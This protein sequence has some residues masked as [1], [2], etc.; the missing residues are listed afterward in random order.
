[1]LSFSVFDVVYLGLRSDSLD[2]VN[3]LFR[4]VPYLTL[5][6]IIIYFFRVSLFN[7][8]SI[9]AQMTQLSLRMSLCQFIQSYADYSKGIISDNKDLLVRFE[10]IIFSNIVVTEENI[11][12]TYDGLEQLAT[13]IGTLKKK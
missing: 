12:S 6:I 4:L 10:N 11:P 3:N 7:F 5:M 8:R 2:I 13:M 1:M 9:K